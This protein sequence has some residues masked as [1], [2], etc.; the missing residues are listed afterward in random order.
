M[1]MIIVYLFTFISLFSMD[2][3]AKFDIAYGIFG[4]VG[5]TT[6]RTYVDQQNHYK[7]DLH[8]QTHGL[9]HFLSG[10]REEWYISVG[11]V[12]KKGV[13]IPD[14]F[15]KTVKQTVSNIN[16]SDENW[17]VETVTQKYTFYHDQ[18][19]IMIEETKKLGEKI[20]NKEK[21]QLEY[22]ASYDLLSLFLNFPKVLPNLDLHKH[23][24]LYAV[25]A[26]D[27]DGRV[28]VLPVDNTLS[29]KNKFDWGDGH[30]LKVILNQKIFASSKGELLLNLGADG[31][32]KNG[33]LQDVI[34]F[35]DI[36]GTRVF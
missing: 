25:G 26:N 1:R 29:I 11:N 6:T 4:T 32:A 33:V 18:K 12:N 21:K 31:L 19:K 15:E 2:M 7:I 36:R 24:V 16:G 20:L 28:D 10:N 27:K 34:L 3:T 23:V 14:T 30:I 8:V 22:Y 9:A 17:E 5:T 13:F 35:G